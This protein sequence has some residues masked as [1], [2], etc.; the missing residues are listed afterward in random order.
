[1]LVRLD[2]GDVF[3]TQIV[4]AVRQPVDVMLDRANDIGQ[5]RR[6]SRPGDGEHVRETCDHQAQQIARAILPGRFRRQTVTADDVNGQQRAGHRVIAGR[7]HD[8]VER[9]FPA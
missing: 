8:G 1:M 4:E 6:T 9:V 2:A 3:A 5:N 7:E